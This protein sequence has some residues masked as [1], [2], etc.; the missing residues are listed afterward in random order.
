MTRTTNSTNVLPDAGV[1][2]HHWVVAAVVG[3]LF[4]LV[5]VLVAW[6]VVTALF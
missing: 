6:I 1:A 5:E 4:G 2:R 3:V